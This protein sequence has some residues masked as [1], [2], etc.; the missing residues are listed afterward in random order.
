M[1]REVSTSAQVLPRAAL[2]PASQSQQRDALRGGGLC[3]LMGDPRFPS[4]TAPAAAEG[5]PV[6]L[7]IL[8]FFRKAARTSIKRSKYASI[9]ETSYS[10]RGPET[11]S[12]TG[13]AD[14][15]EGRGEQ[16][17]AGGVRARREAAAHTQSSSERSGSDANSSSASEQLPLQRVSGTWMGQ[18]PHIHGDSL[19]GPSRARSGTFSSG[20]LQRQPA[21]SSVTAERTGQPGFTDKHTHVAGFAPTAQQLSEVAQSCPSLCDPTDCSPPGS[22]IHGILQAG[23][24]DW[25]AISR[26]AALNCVLS[27]QCTA[28]SRLC[29]CQ[30][31]WGA[32]RATCHGGQVPPHASG[33]W[34]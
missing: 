23:R 21:P 3:G 5:S 2:S 13:T 12:P 1:N 11:Q 8:H 17:R 15:G 31:I 10:S 27:A 33:S 20:G 25:V 24:L 7:S 14:T 18:S 6:P 19:A 4:P 28:L 9:I 26:A 30:R 29:V 32:C 22:S 34:A 16:P